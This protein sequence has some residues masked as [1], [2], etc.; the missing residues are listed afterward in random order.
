MVLI[1]YKD[2]LVQKSAK[3]QVRVQHI[4][5][6]AQGIHPPLLLSLSSL[7]PYGYCTWEWGYI[8][9]N[10]FLVQGSFN[11]PW[12]ADGKHLW[13][14]SVSKSYIYRSLEQGWL[15]KFPSFG[16][17]MELKIRLHFLSKGNSP[18]L[19]NTLF[20]IYLNRLPFFNIVPSL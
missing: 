3:A 7:N 2:L 5:A 20:I 9:V 1:C 14:L 17:V 8:T 6:V 16:L 13:A 15:L 12:D 18:S 11:Q 10:H 19:I 4:L